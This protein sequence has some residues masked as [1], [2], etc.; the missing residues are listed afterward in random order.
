MEFTNGNYYLAECMKYN[1]TDFGILKACVFIDNVR[2]FTDD[3]FHKSRLNSLCKE[4]NIKRN[5][6]SALGDARILIAVFDKKPELLDHPYGY[7]FKDI[8]VYLNG[9]LPRSIPPLYTRAMACCSYARV[10]LN[11]IC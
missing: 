11:Q 4:L 7:T 2:I 3:G 9:K 8:V 10:N 5:I 1:F 6:H